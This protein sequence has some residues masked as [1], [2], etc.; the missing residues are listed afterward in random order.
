VAAGGESEKCRLTFQ[1][2]FERTEGKPERWGKPFAALLGAYRAQ[3][4]FGCGAIGGKDSMSGTFE[5]IDVPPTLVSFAVVTAKADNIISAEFKC[6]YSRIGYIAPEYDE[7][8]LPDFD[9]VKRVFRTVEKLIKDKKAISV[10]SVAHGGAAEGVFKMTLGNR[11]GA[12][13]YEMSDEELFTPVY[14]AF[15]MELDGD[16]DAK[17]VRIIGETIPEF[18]IKSGEL[19]LNLAQLEDKWENVLEPVFKAKLPAAPAPEKAEH[20]GGCEL[21]REHVSHKIAK[22]RVLIPVFPGTNCE[23]DMARA[24]EKEG[25]E[26]EIFVIKNLNANDV[27]ESVEEFAKRIDGAQ[28]IA[29][30][31]GFSGGDEPEGSAKF[32]AA[33]FRNDRV[34]ESTERLLYTRDGLM[35]GI[36]NGFQA[37]IK[38]GLVPYG[39]IVTQTENA[40]TLTYNKIGR[41]Q[42]QLVY[43]RICTD[44]SPWLMYCE[45]GDIHSIPIS[46]GEGRFVAPEEEIKRLMA[47][48][49]IATQYVDLKGNPTLDAAYNPNS[50]MCAIEG[51]ISPDGRVLGKMGHTE[52]LTDFCCKNV[53]GNK[54]Q[55]LFKGGVDYFA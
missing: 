35:I 8:G 15:V 40:P 46:H 51:I 24:F 18:E 32:I 3:L 11:V 41:H 20:G 38:L 31:G 47:N 12:K 17:G 29:L 49:Q 45:P 37:L 36:C 53:D 52:R 55:P 16:T 5:D 48:G 4:E 7:N 23:Y 21:I 26:S 19:T 9:S 50:S 6:P 39:H 54:D 42:S 34:K 10:W 33:F 13:L 2:Y 28:I 27:E 22:P 43:T 30:P 44:N 1:E 14:G 25:A